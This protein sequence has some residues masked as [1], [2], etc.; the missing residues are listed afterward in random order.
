[1][2]VRDECRGVA[3]VDFPIAL[4]SKYT[5]RA[6]PVRHGHPSTI[7]LW[8]ARR[9]LAPSRPVADVQ[10]RNPRFDLPGLDTQSGEPRLIEVKGLG[11]PSGTISLTPNEKR[12]AEDRGECYWLYVVTHCDTGSQLQAIRDPASLPWHEVKKVDHYWL[13]VDA[14][15]QALRLREGAQEKGR[16]QAPGP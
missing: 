13:S 9:L 11:G 7:H 2:S 12:V 16:W 14:A 8:W 1:M 3:E 6:K 15:G 5:A 4:V 10:E